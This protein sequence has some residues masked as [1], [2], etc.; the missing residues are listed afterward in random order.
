MSKYNY[1]I[2]KGYN[3]KQKKEDHLNHAM[4]NT[5]ATSS[6]QKGLKGMFGS[7]HYLE[8]KDWTHHDESAK[9]FIADN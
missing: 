3:S 4:K 2:S 9:G 1:Q 7:M 6:P 8:D 5:N